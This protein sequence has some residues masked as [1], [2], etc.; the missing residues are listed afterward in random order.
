MMETFSPVDLTAVLAAETLPK[1]GKPNSTIIGW[2]IVL[3]ILV[4]IGL[5]CLINYVQ[6]IK[7]E[8]KFEN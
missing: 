6:D 8:I 4:L 5:Y 7:A 3:I 2:K 1:A